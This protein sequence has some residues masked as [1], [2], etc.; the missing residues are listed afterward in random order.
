MFIF[1]Y[2]CKYIL[3]ATQKDIVFTAMLSRT[4]G[5]YVR[6]ASRPQSYISLAPP[7]SPNGLAGIIHNSLK[8]L[9][10]VAEMFGKYS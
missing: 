2:V 8:Y 4:T 3:L 7:S 9:S 6:Q 1:L 10:N 5:F